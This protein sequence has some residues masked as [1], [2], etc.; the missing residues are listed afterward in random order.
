MQARL[1]RGSLA[2]V[3]ILAMVSL[4]AVVSSTDAVGALAVNTFSDD[5]GNVHEKNIEFIAELGITKGCNPPANTNYCPSGT[6]TRGQMAAFL[7]RALS[8]PAT[9]VDFFLDDADSIFQNDINKLAAAGITSGC[10]PPANTNF[11]PDGKVTR[12]QMAAFLKR[13][14]NLAGA[15]KDYFVDDSTSIF[16]GDINRLAASG[17]TLGCNPPSNTNFCP[18]QSVRR[19]QMAS[20][21]ARALTTNVPPPTTTPPTTVPTN[22]IV[23]QTAFQIYNSGS[24]AGAT[25]AAAINTP[26]VIALNTAFSIRVGVSNTGSASIAVAPK[27]QYRFIGS[28]LPGPVW[29]NWTNV[30][31]SSARVQAVGSSSLTDNQI[32][33]ERLAG[34]LPFIAGRIDEAD[35]AIASV[36]TLVPDRESEFVFSV[37]LITPTIQNEQYEFRL[38][39]ATGALFNSY[40]DA[41]AVNL[42]FSFANGFDTG[43]DGVIITPSGSANPQ[44]WSGVIPLIDPGAPRYATD[45]SFEG[46]MSAKF[47]R[48]ATDP[49]S[50]VRI[51]DFNQAHD[52]YGRLYFRYAGLPAPDG[53]RIVD[54]VGGFENGDSNSHSITLTGV[55]AVG[56]AGRINMKAGG[57]VGVGGETNLLLTPVLAPNTWHRIEWHATTETTLGAG[58]GSFEVRIYDATGSLLDTGIIAS[59]LAFTKTEFEDADFGPRSQTVTGWIDEVKMS[60]T[61]WVGP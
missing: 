15:S 49:A 57:V 51:N 23:S 12:G 54:V 58:N 13:A 14:F 46:G 11:C 18:G 44:A 1:V 9:S 26:A 55:D 5:D 20:F 32:T 45:Q 35:G 56:S 6:V 34:P 3:L 50:Y 25:A 36:A 16:E 31:A 27:L 30:T 52:L 60:N 40:G 61:G 8:L 59:P 22:A 10:N 7:A 38:V 4:I 29:S 33:S 47:D 42:P 24:E 2:M 39:D 28:Q 41:P 53:T 21:L 17:I 37:K 48:L 19:D 43:T